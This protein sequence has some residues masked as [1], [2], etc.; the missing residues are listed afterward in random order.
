[1]IDSFVVSN[2]SGT[3]VGAGST[4]MTRTGT[5]S[6]LS[7][8]PTEPSSGASAHFSASGRIARLRGKSPEW[9][10]GVLLG[11]SSSLRSS[12]RYAVGVRLEAAQRQSLT[13]HPIYSSPRDTQDAVAEELEEKRIGI[14]FC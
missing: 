8:T 12:S 11:L 5:T 7:F 3:G 4:A 2:D 13:R 10:F 9:S 6:A 14:F 1:M